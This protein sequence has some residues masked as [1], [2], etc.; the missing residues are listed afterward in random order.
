MATL[1]ALLTLVFA[2]AASPATAEP[3][4]PILVNNMGS[5]VIEGGTD[6][7]TAAE[8]RHVDEQPPTSVI[9]AVGTPPSNGQLELRTDPFNPIMDF[10]QAQLDADLIVY[11]HDDTNT[12]TDQ[13]DFTVTDGLGNTL[14]AQPFAITITPVG[15]LTEGTSYTLTLDGT[16]TDIAGNPLGDDVTI[17]F[18]MDAL[19]FS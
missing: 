5:N 14:P 2:T 7:I 13:F 16:I 6:T 12:V 1:C 4:A 10:T 8:L 17:I 3:A 15:S 11:V 19:G 18:D 9:Y